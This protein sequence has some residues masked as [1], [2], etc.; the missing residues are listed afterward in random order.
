MAGSLRDQLLKAGVV[1]KQK[2][3]QVEQEQRKKRKQTGQQPDPEAQARAAAI[4]AA[5]EEK[6]QRDRERQAALQQAQIAK[7]QQ[8]EIRQLLDQHRIPVPE[9]GQIR[10]HFSWQGR[11]QSL[12]LNR[13]LQ[14]R[15]ISG[16]VCLVFFEQG[17]HL[18]AAEVGERIRAR[19][20]GLL[21]ATANAE[22]ERV[23]AEEAE[24]ADYPVPDDLRW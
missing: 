24:Y 9:D 21:V 1:D 18:V 5:R 11:I 23:A 7:A 13:D 22:Q 6:Q 12:W 10:Y 14:E 19:D 2:V 15:V 3:K 20:P 4:A 17:F 16:T 8:A